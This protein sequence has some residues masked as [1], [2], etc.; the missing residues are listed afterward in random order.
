MFLCQTLVSGI[1]VVEKTAKPA[2]FNQGVTRLVVQQI[3]ACPPL[4]QTFLTV[5]RLG[6]SLRINSET[7]HF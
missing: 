2:R 5:P 1:V 4:A 7:K 3:S 6:N